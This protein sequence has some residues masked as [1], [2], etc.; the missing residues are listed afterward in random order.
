MNAKFQAVFHFLTCLALWLGL[1]TASALAA[2]Q[3]GVVLLRGAS[4]FGMTSS[5]TGQNYI[6]YLSVPEA[7]APTGGYPVL[8]ALDGDSSFPA[9]HL[10]NPRSAEALAMQAA[11]G[12][13][14]PDPGIVVAIG[15][16]RDMLQTRDL[17]SRDY[18]PPLQSTSS[19][20]GA[21]AFALFIERELKPQIA[22]R[23]PINP[24]RQSLLGHSYGGLFTLYRLLQQPAAFQR[25]FAISPS[26]WAAEGRVADMGFSQPPAARLALWIGGN[27]QPAAAVSADPARKTRVEAR[28]MLGK[29]QAFAARMQA[30]PGLDTDFRV[31][32][33]H[34]HGEMA[35]YAYA[36]VLRLAFAAD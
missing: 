25:Y 2:G 33:D 16:G 13:N 19:P 27:E 29:A 14:A 9:L 1:G 4:Q 11:H 12:R 20:S 36:R 15:Y 3:D 18:L 35:I 31:V 28:N 32:P 5:Y 23:F 21:D 22:A 26:L 7:P 17:R 30:V 8:Y 34:D 24:A 6:I 10:A